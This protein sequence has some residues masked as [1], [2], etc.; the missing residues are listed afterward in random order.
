MVFQRFHL[1]GI[2]TDP[3]RPYADPIQSGSG[4]GSATLIFRQLFLVRLSLQVISLTSRP[5]TLSVN[6]YQVWIILKSV[7]QNPRATW[8]FF[9]WAKAF[10]IW[11]L[12]GGLLSQVPHLILWYKCTEY[13]IMNLIKLLFQLLEKAVFT[14][15]NF[16]DFGDQ[17]RKAQS[18][19]PG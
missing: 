16:Y 19:P 15:S 5:P 7:N 17:K 10:D 1:L 14:I 2:D 13:H 12:E 8:A 6:T 9:V 18:N 11:G 4:Y 3:V